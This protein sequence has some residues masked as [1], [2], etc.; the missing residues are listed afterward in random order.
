M[1]QPVPLY[2]DEGES[3]LLQVHNLP[4]DLQA[5]TWYRAIYRVPYFEIV[6]CSRVLNTTTWGNQYSRRETVYPNGSLLL[7]DITEKDEG[8]YT[9]EILKSDFKIEKS[10][11]QFHVNSK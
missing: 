1:I 9:L 3:V 6:K 2:A 7:Q 5:F 10:Y 8:M 4:E 11:V